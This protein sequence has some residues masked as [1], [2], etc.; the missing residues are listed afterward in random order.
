LLITIKNNPLPIKKYSVDLPS[1][2]NTQIMK[3]NAKYILRKLGWVTYDLTILTGF[4]LL[5]YFT[6]TEGFNTVD[7]TNLSTTFIILIGFMFVLSL[8]ALGGLF[9]VIVKDINKQSKW[10]IA[11][12]RK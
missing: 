7:L 11:A 3:D 6:L 2:K 4:S 1:N 12:Y 5:L 10:A 8:F 9:V